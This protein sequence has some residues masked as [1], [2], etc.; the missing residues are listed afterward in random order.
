MEI[1]AP[2]VAARREHPEDDLISVLVQV[3][4]HGR[5]RSNAPAHATPRSIRSPCCCWP[6]ARARRGSRWASRWRRCCS[7]PESCRGGAAGSSTAPPG[8]RGVVAVAT[9]GSD[10]LALGDRGHRVLR[11]APSEGSGPP[12]LPRRG[13]PGPRAL[14]TSGR[15]RPLPPSKAHSG[16]RERPS[17]LPRTARG[18]CRDD[19]RH[20]RAAGPSPQPPARPRRRA[21]A[22]SSASTSVGPRPS[23]S[24]S[25]EEAVR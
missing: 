11:H 13:E 3:R 4:D 17:R 6:P 12:Y 5:G 9:D 21:A 8:H 10:V 19:D 14:G 16:L 15:L 7:D 24:C 2:I 18:S 25:A 22:L 20:Q 23:R 1:I